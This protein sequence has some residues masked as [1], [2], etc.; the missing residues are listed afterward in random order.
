MMVD[1]LTFCKF[2]T[3]FYEKITLAVFKG[4]YHLNKKGY[5]VRRHTIIPHF[6]MSPLAVRV[7][8]VPKSTFL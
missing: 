8:N 2:H 7:K 4:L 5:R 3:S 6:L 1:F